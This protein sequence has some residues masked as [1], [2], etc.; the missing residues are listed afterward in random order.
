MT[1]AKLR[2]EEIEKEIATLIDKIVSAS[3]A[4]MEYTNERVDVLDTEK[5]AV[6]E[7]IAQLSAEMYDRSNVGAISGYMNNW[8]EIDINDKLSVVDM[9]MEQNK[10]KRS[11]PRYDDAFRAGAVWLVVE[12]HR[13]ARE[14]AAELGICIDTLKSWLQVA[15]VH[16]GNAERKNRDLRRLRELEVE[17]KTLRKQVEI[18]AFNVVQR[19]G[20]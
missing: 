2:A 4:T 7:K 17:V 1:R 14:V 18:C 6:K 5:K 9:L 13:P 12:Q 20:M 16:P 3:T 8:E 11:S 19:C 10:I 15:G